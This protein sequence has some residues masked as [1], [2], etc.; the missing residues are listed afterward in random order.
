M[1]CGRRVR[2]VY[3]YARVERRAGERIGLGRGTQ[4]PAL[5]Y[6]FFPPHDTHFLPSHSLTDAGHPATWSLCTATRSNEPGLPACQA[7]TDP[8]T[9]AKSMGRSTQAA[10]DA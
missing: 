9:L 3:V 8:A 1:R 5:S 7:P 10:M 2:L 6:L 4:H